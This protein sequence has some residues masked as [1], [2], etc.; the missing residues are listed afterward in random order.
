MKTQLILLE[1]HDDTISIRDKMSWAKTPR[2][3]LVWP[4]KGRVDV[5]PLDLALLRRHALSLGAELGL[6]TRDS[7][8]RAAARQMGL[9]VFSKAGHAQRKAWPLRV[10][11][12]AERRTSIALSTDTSALRHAPPAGT[13]QDNVALSAGAPRLD[14]RAV[15]AALPGQQLFAEQSAAVRL[16]IF[17]VGVLAVLLMP[18][19][20]LPSAEI[21][22]SA[23]TRPQ[24][25]EIDVSAEPDVTQVSLTGVIPSHLLTFDFELTDSIHA[26]GQTVAPNQAAEGSVRFTNLSAAAVEVPEGTVVLSLSE[27]P[28]RFATLEAA[29]VPLGK[30]ST[31][32]VR[33]RALAL[34]TAGNVP[35]AAVTA[36]E[37]PLGLSLG[38]INLS[39]MRGGADLT[40]S[41]PTDADRQALHN[42]LLTTIKSEAKKQLSAHSQPG[43][44]LFPLSFGFS[45]VLDETYTPKP[46]QP[47]GK[48]TLTLRAEFHAY[49][50]SAA[51]L[52]QL[53]GQA[54]DASLP[55]GYEPVE[56]TLDI[57][58]VS[59]LFGGA[60]GLT[61]WRIRG[62]RILRARIDPAQVISIVRG[63]TAGRARGLLQE[64][65][66][67]ESAP[68]ISIQ[69][70]FWPWLPSLP[71]QIKVTG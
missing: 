34:G 26:S 68:Q 4:N 38:V 6:V 18:L 49:Y 48:L 64:T 60:Q 62:L 12:R 59:P 43:D 35:I 30:G 40:V 11:V 27:P 41:A 57:S 1:T 25:V 67:L 50:A 47:G 28:V 15:R 52:K 65:F 14:L 58:S 21:H 46:G 20:F 36:F 3:L 61:R 10:S 37:G 33:V 51:D 39:P 17:S 54:L 32:Y 63:K 29:Q 31:A 55:A 44:V 53:A 7:G 22:L 66:G 16:A 45:K 23:P 2:I 70:F 5:R 9:P 24:S 69:P 8:I 71:F 13:L 42:R 19:F 56:A